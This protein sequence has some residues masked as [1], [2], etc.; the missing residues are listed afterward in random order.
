VARRLY[1]TFKL[2]LG[3]VPQMPHGGCYLLPKSNYLCLLH[4]LKKKE[5]KVKKLIYKLTGNGRGLIDSAI[6]KFTRIK[7]ELEQG[8]QVCQDEIDLHSEIIAESLSKQ[9]AAKKK[10]EQA[11]R[12]IEKLKDFIA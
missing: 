7:D 11:K 8:V 4:L 5:K 6:E 10:S 1:D 2:L 3:L 9:G 12:L